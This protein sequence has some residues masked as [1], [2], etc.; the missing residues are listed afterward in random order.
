[1]VGVGYL[2]WITRASPVLART[3]GSTLRLRVRV[4]PR[5]RLRIRLRVR[6]RVRVRLPSGPPLG[7][8]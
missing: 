2:L 1:M 7:L 3:V 8:G 4:R 6:L 5:V